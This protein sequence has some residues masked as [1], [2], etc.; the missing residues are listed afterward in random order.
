MAPT[1]E[2]DGD[3]MHDAHIQKGVQSFDKPPV[4]EDEY[5]D[6]RPPM[7]VD[8]AGVADTGPSTSGSAPVLP[9]MRLPV[10]FD[11]SSGG[12]FLEGV[13]GMDPRLKACLKGTD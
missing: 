10:S 6:V 3:V 7:A 4:P 8:E 1:M 12:A 5:E 9:W 13:R 11:G 2:H